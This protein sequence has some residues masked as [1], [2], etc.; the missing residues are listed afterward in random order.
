MGMCMYVW[1]YVCMCGY[2]YV[3]MGICMYVWVCVCMYGYMYIC[4]SMYHVLQNFNRKW[5]SSLGTSLVVRPCVR[6]G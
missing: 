6:Y 3:C 2:M 1:V 5:V 4:T